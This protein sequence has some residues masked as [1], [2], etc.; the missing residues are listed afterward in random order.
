MT[1]RAAWIALLRG[2]NVGGRNRLPMSDLVAILESFGLE[3][4]ET[5]IQ[6]GNVVFRSAEKV[7]S[8][9]G[10]EIATAVEERHGFRPRV[11]LLDAGR[12]R[13]AAEANPFPEAEAE[14][15]TLHLFF[16]A[17]APESPDEESLTAVAAPSERFHLAGDVFYLHAPD[18]V[19]RSKLVARVEKHLGVAA[20]AR[21]WRTVERLL[22]MS[23]DR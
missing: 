1:L 2:I 19:G 3:D 14:P 4:V 7:S 22:E 5:Y 23:R 12:L 10:E 8:S 6:S 20:T 11:L 17:S 16:L 9:L 15:K 21:N 13:E 18:G